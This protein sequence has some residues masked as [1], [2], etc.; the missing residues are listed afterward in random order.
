MQMPLRGTSLAPRFEGDPHELQQYL[1]DV[2]LLCEDMQLFADEDRIQW[3]VRYARRIT[4]IKIVFCSFILG[5]HNI[6]G[7]NGTIWV[8]N[9]FRSS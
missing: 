7:I 8:L 3:A 5:V 4:S 9:D 6:G 1:E 2:E